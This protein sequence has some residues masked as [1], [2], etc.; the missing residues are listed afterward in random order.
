VSHSHPYART[1]RWLPD[2]ELDDDTRALPRE[3]VMP[4]TRSDGTVAWP[5]AE[6]DPDGD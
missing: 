6:L 4:C 5:V 1:P 2:D 3:Y